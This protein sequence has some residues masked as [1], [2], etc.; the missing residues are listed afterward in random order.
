MKEI[1][2]SLRAYEASVYPGY[3]GGSGFV[4]NLCRYREGLRMWDEK[5]IRDEWLAFDIERHV[6]WDTTDYSLNP[7]TYSMMIDGYYPVSR[8][9]ML[10]RISHPAVEEFS[11]LAETLE[12]FTLDQHTTLE[13]NGSHSY[14]NTDRNL[15]INWSNHGRICIGVI[16]TEPVPTLEQVTE[17]IVPYAVDVF[18]QLSPTR[19]ISPDTV[20]KAIKTAQEGDKL[21]P[22]CRVEV[23]KT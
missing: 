3:R 6:S 14:T 5:A 18:N 9:T 20:G 17:E 22:H 4:E 1:P 7:F 10:G 13:R 15:F 8:L 19:K 2:V 16:Q 21:L 23:K 11:A 12:G